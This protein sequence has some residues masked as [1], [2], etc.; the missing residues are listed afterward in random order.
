MRLEDAKKRKGEVVILDMVSGAQLTTKIM[1]VTD[2]GY[3]EIGKPMLFQ[4]AVE[5][6]NP[7]MPPSDQNPLEQKVRNGSYGHP[8][9]E[10]QDGTPISIDHIIM[11]HPSHPDMEKVYL[12][13]TSGIQLADASALAQLDAANAPRR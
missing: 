2:D 13:A 3:V 11:I 12:Q 5:P 4:I 1:D 8:L 6:H 7:Q 9:F 10:V